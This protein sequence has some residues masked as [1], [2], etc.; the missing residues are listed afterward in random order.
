MR[1]ATGEMPF[2]DHLE[3]L[4]GRIIKALVAIAIGVG[5]GLWFTIQFKLVEYL[6]APAAP[7]VTGGKLLVLSPMEPVMIYLKLGVVFGIVLASPAVIY[8]IWAFLSP[9]LYARE[10]RAL[11]PTLVA[12][13]ALF[14]AGALLGWFEALGPTLKFLLTYR[15]G[16]FN[17]QITWN[18]YFDFVLQVLIACGISCELPLVMILLAWFD[19]MSFRKYVKYSRYALFFCAVGG[20]ILSPSPDAISMIIWTVP[21]LVLYGIGMGGSYLVER[22]KRSHVAVTTTLLLLAFLAHPRTAHAQLPVSRPAAGAPGPPIA[23]GDTGRTGALPANAIDTGTARR[24]GLPT[25]PA[26]IFPAPDALMQALIDQPDFESTRYLADTASLDA[27]RSRILLGGHAATRRA[28][29]DLEADQIAYDDSR[30]SL[31]AQG[32]PKFFQKGR[33]V[34]GQV[35]QV[36]TC[37]DRAVVSQALTSFTDPGLSGTW[38]M[39]GTLAVDSSAKRLFAANTEFTSCDLPEPHYHFSAGELKWVDQSVIVARPAVLYIRDVPVVWIPFIFDNTRTG[40]HS[41]ILIPQFGFNDIVRPVPSYNR[42]ITNIGYYWAPN[43]YLDV[44]GRFDW[45][46]NR[47]I[48]YGANLEYRWRDQFVQPSSVS[49]SEQRDHGRTSEQLHWS[50]SQRFNLTTTLTLNVNYASSTTQLVNN[51]I[52]PLQS[53]QQISSAANFTKRFRW[54]QVTLGGNRQQS[55]SGGP[56]HHDAAS[57]ADFAQVDRPRIEQQLVAVAHDQQPDPVQRG[58]PG[59]AADRQ[60]RHRYRL[61]DGAVAHLDGELQHALQ[62]PWIYRQHLGPGHRSAGQRPP[63]RDPQ[64]ARSLHARPTPTRSP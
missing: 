63:G 21:L 37:T 26:R 39:R 1:N 36:N 62:H 41:G 18:E 20:A 45:Y 47:Y 23:P 49:F 3:E 46:A 11:I 31:A 9:A 17:I 12:G 64:G 61:G 32:E 57:A 51:A 4:R 35:L 27:A 50:H 16:S 54:G 56:G 13:L 10:K 2:L 59:A 14:I 43:N 8:Q 24:L 60:R 44:T 25:Q 55:L 15:S 42:Q 22:R 58:A 38:F 30:C 53:T 40:R 5:I 19:I 28:D 34:V 7:Y 29:G 6:S 33:I 48:Q 52:D